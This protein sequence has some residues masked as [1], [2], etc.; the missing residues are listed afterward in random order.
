MN[1]GDDNLIEVS[2]DEGNGITGSC[3]LDE[4]AEDSVPYWS[5][6]IHAM[7]QIT[8]P[9]TTS[10]NNQSNI[11]TDLFIQTVSFERVKK[12]PYSCNLSEGLSPSRDL[13]SFSQRLSMRA[14]CFSDSRIN[15]RDTMLFIT[16][17]TSAER[18]TSERKG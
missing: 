5:V 12:K 1:K 6:L 10:L 7:E 16:L 17:S 14:S 13:T 18:W 8:Q 2:R 15:S 9:E 3:H 11:N 4:A